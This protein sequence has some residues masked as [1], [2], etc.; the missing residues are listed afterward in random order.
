MLSG[1]I[2]KSFRDYLTSRIQD[3]EHS[4]IDGFLEDNEIDEKEFKE[5]LEYISTLIVAEGE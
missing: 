4:D 5:L 2:K 1:K 3:F